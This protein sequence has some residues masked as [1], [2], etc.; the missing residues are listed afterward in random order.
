MIEVYGHWRLHQ[1]ATLILRFSCVCKQS[2]TTQLALSRGRFS[3]ND[4]TELN[5]IL[6]RIK[7]LVIDGSGAALFFFGS[8]FK[9]I[10]LN[11]GTDEL[12]FL[13]FRQN[14]HLKESGT[15]CQVSIEIS[16]WFWMMDFT[17]GWWSEF[18]KIVYSVSDY[19]WNFASINLSTQE[20]HWRL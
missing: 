1:H 4:F 13:N 11:F 12:N 20:H 14:S 3:F 5:P 17:F 19:F 8:S 6:N 7:F 9:I 15:Y 10:Q 2:H 18:L 16:T